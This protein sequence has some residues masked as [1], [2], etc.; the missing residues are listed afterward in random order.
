MRRRMNRF[1]KGKK[2]MHGTPVNL[3]LPK[4]LPGTKKASM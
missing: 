2:M 3:V 4:L 1:R